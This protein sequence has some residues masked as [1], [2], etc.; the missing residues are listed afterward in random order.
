[1]STFA[2]YESLTLAPGW[3][4]TPD[5]KS[6]LANR[7]AAKDALIQECKDAV[8]CRFPT[9]C[10]DDALPALSRERG[11]D[12]GPG[13][14]SDVFRARLLQAWN[15]W[16]WA[17]TPYGMLLA[18]RAAGY[19]NVILKTQGGMQYQLQTTLAGVPGSDLIIATTPG[20]VHLGGTP[21]EFWNDFAA[22][23]MTP[24]PSWWGGVAASDGSPDQKAFAALVK[25]WKP[26]HTR[27]VQLKVID[28][29]AWGVGGLTWGSF[30]WGAGT[31]TNWTP[32][33]G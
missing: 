22:L 29:V 24:F 17:G 1:M 32:P 12:R 31:V 11:I 25:K 7:G 15:I 3:L 6:Y 23:V 18:A 5:A 21:S 26:G 9:L 27:C 16:T 2:D 33:V 8:K 28:G 30:T 20:T 10:P 14:S 13:E 4:Q 19:P